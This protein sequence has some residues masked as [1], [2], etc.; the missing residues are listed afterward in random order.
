M[1]VFDQYGSVQLKVGH[2][3]LKQF[4]LGDQVQ[5]PDGVYVGHEGVIVI[6]HQQFI[7]EYPVVHTKWGTELVPAD[8]LC[9]E[10]ANC[11]DIPSKWLPPVSM[12][13]K[14]TD[15]IKLFT[16]DELRSELKLREEQAKQPPKPLANPDLTQL[17]VCLAACLSE[18]ISRGSWNTDNPHYIMEAAFNALYG[19]EF[20]KWFSKEPWKKT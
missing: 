4:N 3:S 9:H 8:I 2:R 12:E 1:G 18:A 20:W 11:H 16:D 14:Q 5:I 13:I 10:V 17:Q 15:P 19:Q 6:H 7:A